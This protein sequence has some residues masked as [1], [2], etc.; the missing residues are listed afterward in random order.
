MRKS[1]E[2]IGYNYRINN[3]G[4]FVELDIHNNNF[5]PSTTSKG[6]TKYLKIMF[7]NDGT[8]YVRFRKQTYIFN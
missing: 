3:C 1:I 8:P 4:T 6:A 5:K 2:E 7:L